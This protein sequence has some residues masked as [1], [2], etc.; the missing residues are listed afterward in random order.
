MEGHIRLGRALS[1]WQ[2]VCLAGVVL[3]ASACAHVERVEQKHDRVL[4]AYQGTL[5]PKGQER[6]FVKCEETTDIH[7]KCSFE[8]EDRCD[9]PQIELVESYTTIE[10]STSTWV[11]I[12]EWAGAGAGLGA[13]LGFTIDAASLPAES[14]P[15]HSNPVGRTGAYLIGCS[16]LA[17][18]VAVATLATIDSIRAMDEVK[19]VT[20]REEVKSVREIACN[21]RPLANQ[22]LGLRVGE[23]SAFVETD[24]A[25]KVLIALN[26]FV[27]HQS[28]IKGAFEP[29]LYIYT[30]AF[31]QLI[32]QTS[33]SRFFRMERRKEDERL[34]EQARRQLEIAETNRKI[35][36]LVEKAVGS[37]CLDWVDVQPEVIANKAEYAGVDD[38]LLCATDGMVELAALFFKQGNLAQGE[39]HR[40]RVARLA[41]NHSR[42]QELDEAR[43]RAFERL[44]TNH[45]RSFRIAESRR[46]LQTCLD[47]VAGDAALCARLEKK[48]ALADVLISL[49][50]PAD[51]LVGALV[52]VVEG[53]A[54]S[55]REVSNLSKRFVLRSGGIK[56]L[57]WVPAHQVVGVLPDDDPAWQEECLLDDNCAIGIVRQLKAHFLLGILV[58][59][60]GQRSSLRVMLIQPHGGILSRNT[61]ELEGP[62]G[63]VKKGIWSKAETLLGQARK[64]A[65][66]SRQA[67]ALAART[68]PEVKDT[69]PLPSDLASLDAKPSPRDP[70]IPP[71]Y[72]E[73]D[74][75][76]VFATDEDVPP[77]HGCDDLFGDPS[78]M[79][80]AEE[81]AIF[82]KPR[83]LLLDL[84]TKGGKRIPMGDPFLANQGLVRTFMNTFRMKR[85]IYIRPCKPVALRD[86]QGKRLPGV[87]FVF[88][89][90]LDKWA[91]DKDEET[92]KLE[93][94][95]AD[96]SLKMW[97]LRAGKW[98]E[99]GDEDVSVPGYFDKALFLSQDVQK[100]V[101]DKA[102]EAAGGNI[103]GAVKSAGV[104]LAMGATGV[105]KVLEKTGAG[106][107]LKKTGAVD[108]LKDAAGL[109]ND[110]EQNG[111][112]D[113]VEEGVNFLK[114]GSGG[115]VQERLKDK[116]KDWY[117]YKV[118]QT[119][120]MAGKKLGVE[121]AGYRDFRLRSPVLSRDDD[122][123]GIGVGDSEGVRL[124]DTFLFTTK[125][126]DDWEGFG[127]VA[128]VGAG[129]AKGKVEQTEV[130]VIADYDSSDQQI[131][132]LEYP[133]VGVMVGVSA[134]LLPVTHQAAQLFNGDTVEKRIVGMAGL[135]LD[136]RWRIPWIPLCEL[137]QT[138]RVNFIFD[139]PLTIFT[140]DPG[141]EKRWFWGRFAPLLG[142]R[143]SLG[144]VSVPI[145]KPGGTGDES[146][147]A[148]GLTHGM[149]GYLGF[150]I[151]FHPAVTLSLH[152]GWRQ[153]FKKLTRFKYEGSSYS[154]QTAE[155]TDLKVD[156]SG[157][158]ALLGLTYEY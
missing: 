98:E 112:K 39:E 38:L 51:K 145:P 118:K 150:N 35:G 24:E 63:E 70:S 124:S 82:K 50:L 76:A 32:H 9:V 103:A 19:D 154:I 30:G 93:F 7:V 36:L 13:G 58:K 62:H 71:E 152:A 127:R 59:R 80:V 16:L 157:P 140:V 43:N 74:L 104:N 100:A 151:F 147:T 49:D 83:V 33:T 69:G 27:D 25:G 108:A 78:R 90:Q 45:L 148:T 89:V 21:H 106:E 149:E 56:E 115:A 66:E 6:Y 122:E 158:F 125:G 11:K 91:E 10:N 3:L 28:V 77:P 44:V 73:V 156:L 47:A 132:V 139:L 17:A 67:R 129:G 96:L 121:V 4:Q 68:K 72:A 92:K 55:D 110:D 12:L 86:I 142:I 144:I 5:Y 114:V 119:L 135:S 102:L 134:G 14:D 18:G 23:H 84:Q 130:E 60:K 138:N 26:S 123:V 126:P 46:M 79:P 101:I 136:A 88:Q 61:L 116:K 40:K 42:L 113:Y 64:L 120:A 2:P 153:Y 141:F 53:R 20:R 41:P 57:E 128:H 75:E 15:Y 81:G 109:G 99:Y 146:E 137:Y 85:N 105:G 155:G 65:R 52:A 131:Q 111:L 8:V 31:Q 29:I 97:D 87:D 54:E 133:I 94:V 22:K 107:V 1:G 143:Y 48:L 117:V 37:Q 95:N 34:A